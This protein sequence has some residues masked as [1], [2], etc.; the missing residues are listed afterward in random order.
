MTVLKNLLLL[1][2]VVLLV[3][4]THL[5]GTGHAAF[6]ELAQVAAE[7]NR[8]ADQKGYAWVTAA[9]EQK[10]AKETEAGKAF[11][12]TGRK[13]TMVDVA[14]YEGEEALKKGDIEAAMKKA[15]QAKDIAEAQQTQQEIS[16]KYQRLWR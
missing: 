5:S 3:G 12:A 14:L 16:S 2:G 1:Q 11:A 4:C 10:Y 7:K 8:M 15:K 9:I 13:L 6:D